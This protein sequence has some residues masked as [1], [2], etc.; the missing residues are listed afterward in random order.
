M[1]LFALLL[2]LL[3][4]AVV[5]WRATAR[6]TQAETAYPPSGQFIEVD[7]TRI[8]LRIEGEGPDL[9]LIHG[10]NGSIRDFTFELMGRLTD[11]YRVIMV[12]RPGLG[13][14]GRANGPYKGVWRSQAEAP[15]VQARLMQKAVDQVGVTRPIVLGHSYGGAVALAWAIDRPE[16]TAAVVLLGAVSNPWP[17]SLGPLYQINSTRIGSALVIPL[18][19]A[20]APM[21]R[22]EDTVAAIFEPQPTPDGYLDHFGPELTLRRTTLRANAQQVNSLRPH[23]VEMA[24]QYPDLT[25]PVEILHGTDDTIVP[26]R[27][28]SEP[29]AQLLPNATLTRMEGVGHM[30][31]HADPD[32]VEA[33]IDR[34]AARAGLR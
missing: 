3:T 21:A 32:A 9:V 5:H 8:H 11:R 15:A 13:W 29:L 26:L 4:V 20:F 19:S 18:I 31:H 14:S 23:V 12:D 24:T 2:I 10:A 28:H 30:P 27:V 22:I 16:D 33:A 7:G 17:G 6:E 25:L 34:A 1:L